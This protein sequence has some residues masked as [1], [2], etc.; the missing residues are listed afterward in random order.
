MDGDGKRNTAYDLGFHAW[1]NEQAA[2]NGAA[3]TG[4]RRSRNSAGGLPGACETIQALVPEPTRP[5]PTPTAMQCCGRI[6]V[7]KNQTKSNTS[8]FVR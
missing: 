5:W 2:R 7:P 4:S 3:E 6:P 8:L 1:A